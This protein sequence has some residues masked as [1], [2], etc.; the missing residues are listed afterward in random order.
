M[1]MQ[2]AE[3]RATYRVG[4]NFFEAVAD[5]AAAAVL[6]GFGR[7]EELEADEV[8]LEIAARAG[9]QAKGLIEFLGTLSRINAESTANAGLFRSHPE[10]DERIQ[11]ASRL[12]RKKKLH[13]G[14]WLADRFAAQVPYEVSSAGTGE[15]VA[16]ARGMAGTG[17]EAGDG[18][19]GEIEEETAEESASMDKPEQEDE[20]RGSHFSLA[21]LANPFEMGS[22]EESAEVTAAGAGR[23]VGE[24]ADAVEAGAKNPAM[25]EIEITAEELAAFRRQGRLR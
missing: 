2:L 10:T 22:E 25:V 6:A 15:A 1:G 9:Y 24:E 16:G 13:N 4:S 8:G 17:E 19:A 12:I 18:G 23:A 7:A 20:Q 3:N 5:K 11:K 14:E 21:D